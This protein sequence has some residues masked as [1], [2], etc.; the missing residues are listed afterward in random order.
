MG[1]HVPQKHLE[2]ISKMT[3]T[4]DL[5]KLTKRQLTN[6]KKYYQ[7]QDFSGD[8]V[9]KYIA[10]D[11]WNDEGVNDHPHM[12]QDW[13][14]TRVHNFPCNHKIWKDIQQY[15]VMCKLADTSV[16]E[17]EMDRINT[18]LSEVDKIIASGSDEPVSQSF[19]TH[20][21]HWEWKRDNDYE[22][23]PKDCVLKKLLSRIHKTMVPMNS[24]N[25]GIILIDSMIDGKTTK[26]QQTYIGEHND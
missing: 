9:T 12:D 20:K 4:F 16:Y 10:R 8:T 18:N 7:K 24:D 6:V 23:N 1:I 15:L 13:G 26:Y 2:V 11:I 17:L 22:E 19:A 3:A 21:V 25:P 5:T 14:K